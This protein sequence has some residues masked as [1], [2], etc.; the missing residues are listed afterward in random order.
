MIVKVCDKEINKSVILKTSVVLICA[1][2]FGRDTFALP[3]NC[4][5]ITLISVPAFLF[6]DSPL[7]TIAPIF[8]DSLA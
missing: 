4:H 6:L 8:T 3:I 1:L 2:L 7:F 5:V